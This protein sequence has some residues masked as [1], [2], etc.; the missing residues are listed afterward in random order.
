MSKIND[1]A[2]YDGGDE[3]AK[4]EG[5]LTPRQFMEKWQLTPPQ[6]GSMLGVKI[7]Q[8]DRLIAKSEARRQPPTQAQADRLLELDLLLTMRSKAGDNRAALAK[9][10]RMVDAL[11][12]MV[13]FLG[14]TVP[15]DFR[16]ALTCLQGN[17]DDVMASPA[18]KRI[19]SIFCENQKD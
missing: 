14:I 12:F 15:P 10:D 17:A 18:V 2:D 7:A 3:L 16:D 9:I 19:D 1:E 13:R 8:A 11:E 4:T 5:Q 6:L